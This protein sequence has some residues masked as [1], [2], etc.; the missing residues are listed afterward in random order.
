MNGIDL[1]RL[2]S[3]LRPSLPFI[4]MTGNGPMD[5]KEIAGMQILQKPWTDGEL[6]EEIAKGL[7]ID[8]RDTDRSPPNQVMLPGM[9]QRTR[10]SQVATY[11][12]H[13]VSQRGQPDMECG[14]K[15]PCTAPPVLA[16]I[17]SRRFRTGHFRPNARVRHATRLSAPVESGASKTIAACG[18]HPSRP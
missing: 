10:G 4:L 8:P 5:P 2:V 6:V 18:A 12:P 11:R 9:K 14:R 15:R 17:G 3:G 13:A 1:A 7:K 16:E